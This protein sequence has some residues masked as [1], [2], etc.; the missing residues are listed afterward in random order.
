MTEMLPT[1]TPVW[2]DASRRNAVMDLSKEGLKPAMMPT[3]NQPMSAQTPVNFPAAAMESFRVMK[4]ATTATAPTMTP[5]ETTANSLDAAMASCAAGSKQSKTATKL[6]TMETKST[7]MPVETIVLPISVATA[8]SAPAKTVTTATTTPQTRVT[9]VSAVLVAMASS[10]GANN[11]M[12]EI[13]T[14]ETTV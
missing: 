7:M 2:L 9:T 6:A 8:S 14:I 4:D 10:K 5:V 12:M 13:E 1:M 11:A 3:K